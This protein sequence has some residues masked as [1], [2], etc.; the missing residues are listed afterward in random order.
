MTASKVVERNS[1]ANRGNK[2]D[3]SANVAPAAR[4]TASEK[5]IKVSVSQPRTNRSITIIARHAIDTP[6]AKAFLGI[7]A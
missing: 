7:S 2:T 3:R 4:M 5:S 6:K 1:V